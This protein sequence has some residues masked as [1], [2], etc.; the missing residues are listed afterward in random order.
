MLSSDIY[1]LR[2]AVLL[3]PSGRDPSRRNY[4]MDLRGGE[5]SAE[6]IGVNSGLKPHWRKR[7]AIIGLAKSI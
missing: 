1:L 5:S 6:K 3:A 4:A 7:F 2:R